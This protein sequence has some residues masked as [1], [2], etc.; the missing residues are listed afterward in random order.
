MRI[1][2]LSNYSIQVN[3]KRNNDMLIQKYKKK[4][5]K[6]QDAQVHPLIT[7]YRLIVREIIK[8]SYKNIRKKAKAH[9]AQA[10][11]LCL[12][13]C[14]NSTNLNVIISY[15]HYQ[16]LDSDGTLK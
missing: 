8:C 14:R 7:I 12:R 2:T 9:H 10:H 4:T 16:H 1:N 5:T 15:L 6:A 3:C 11:S 13:I